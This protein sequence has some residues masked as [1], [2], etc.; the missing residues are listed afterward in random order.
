MLG[1]LRLDVSTLNGV[2]TLAGTV[3]SQAD[4]DRAVAAA[5]RAAGVKAV[6][7]ALKIGS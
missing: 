7:S 4:A 5:K 6:T 2:V 3:P 1:A